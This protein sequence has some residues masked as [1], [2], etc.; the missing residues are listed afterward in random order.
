MAAEL[1]FRHNP[2]KFA[3]NLFNHNK[4]AGIPDFTAD[5]AHTYFQKVYSDE[6]R[7]HTYTQLP[8]IPRPE[9]PSKVFNTNSPSLSE[10]QKSVKRKRN[11][12]APGFNQFSNVC[13]M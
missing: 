13:A 1:K 9:L 4:Q 5:V 11:G 2:N 7:S 3:N 6:Q 10:L 8:E 12:A